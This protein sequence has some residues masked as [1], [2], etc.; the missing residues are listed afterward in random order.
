MFIACPEL[1]SL[2][3][4]RGLYRRVRS[5]VGE[6]DD[7][8]ILAVGGGSCIDLAKVIEGETWH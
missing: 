4:F 2:N 7:I 6:R 3:E 8:V 1:S 5:F